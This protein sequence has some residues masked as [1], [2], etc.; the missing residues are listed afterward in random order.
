MEI[1]ARLY[2]PG[3]EVGLVELLE[4]C[5]PGWPERDLNCSKIDYWK[6][7]YVDNPKGVNFNSVAVSGDQIVAC[8]HGVFYDTKMGPKTVLGHKATDLATHPEFRKQGITKL[9]GQKKLPLHAKYQTAFTFTIAEN[10]IVT[11]RIRRGNPLFPQD[12]IELI[13]I[14]DVQLHLKMTD[15]SRAFFKYP[16]VQLVKLVES[17]RTGSERIEESENVMIRKIIKF[18]EKMDVFYNS[19]KPEY[20]FIFERTSNYLNW[21]YCDPRGGN[22]MVLIAQEDETILGYIVLRINKYNP[23]YPTGW[24]VDLFTKPDNIKVASQLLNVANEVFD[25]ENI[26]IVRYWVIKGHPLEEVFKKHGYLDIRKNA[27]SVVVNPRYIG[28]EY[29]IFMNSKPNQL[30]LQAGDTE[31]I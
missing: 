5:F 24:V 23:E 4:I 27:P 22:Y 15:T 19:I 6:W 7:K 31:Y 12:L 14:K 1:I 8:N 28:D 30:H 20:N 17:I 10:P 16:I 21:R 26:N 2:E 13:R 3:D 9:M 18:D 29:Q 11:E 25:N